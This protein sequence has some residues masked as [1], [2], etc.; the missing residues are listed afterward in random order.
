[1]NYPALKA[2]RRH[3]KSAAD[4]ISGSIRKMHVRHERVMA[5]TLRFDRSIP[6]AVFGDYES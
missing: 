1:M 6:S 3:V 2:E 5:T 4:E